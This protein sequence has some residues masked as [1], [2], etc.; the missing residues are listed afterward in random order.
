MKKNLLK[1]ALLVALI[2][3]PVLFSGAASAGKYQE[4]NDEIKSKLTPVSESITGYLLDR[5]NK[6]ITID[7]YADVLNERASGVYKSPVGED[8]VPISFNAK[9]PVAF[10]QE[11]LDLAEDKVAA[12]DVIH[13][14]IGRKYSDNLDAVNIHKVLL[15]D[16]RVAQIARIN[17]GDEFN[18]IKKTWRKRKQVSANLDEYVFLHELFHLAAM[19][20]DKSI[21]TA[22]SEGISDVSA[23][24]TMSTTHSLTL[25]QTIDLAREVSYGRRSEAKGKNEGHYDKDLLGKM[26]NYF[27]TMREKGL[28]LHRVNSLQEANDYALE[29]ALDMDNV[30]RKDTKGN[31]MYWEMGM[32][33]GEDKEESIARRQSFDEILNIAKSNVKSKPNINPE[34]KQDDEP[35]LGM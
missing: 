16:G 4:H 3:A 25:D 12:K 8:C 32:K 9:E 13:L 18:K 21:P 34:N 33:I 26:L 20:F 28:D 1:K 29:I 10:Y 2:S 7:N 15:K 27:E 30:K 19:N 6:A 24:I 31:K 11:I 35:S 5:C 23:V 14:L 22:V 17:D